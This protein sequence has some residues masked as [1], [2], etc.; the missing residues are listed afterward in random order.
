MV[1]HKGFTLIELMV[2]VAIVGIIAAVAYPAYLKSAQKGRRGDAKSAL[3]QY[4]QALERCYTEFGNY[5]SINCPVY[6]KLTGVGYTSTASL[7]TV[8]VSNLTNTTYTLTATA[9]STGPQ[10]KDTGCT[11]MTLDNTGTQ[12]PSGCW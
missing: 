5:Q 1:R 4:A 2:T 6:S 12:G 3:T 11:A 10:A 7:Y 8:T 9:V